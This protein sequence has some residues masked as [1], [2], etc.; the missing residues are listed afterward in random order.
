MSSLPLPGY[1][2]NAARWSF[3]T[4]ED[5]GRMAPA[6]PVFAGNAHGANSCVLPFQDFQDKVAAKSGHRHHD[7]IIRS[8]GHACKILRFVHHLGPEVCEEC[9]RSS[10]S[11]ARAGSE[12][13][14]GRN[15][16]TRRQSHAGFGGKLIDHGAPAGEADMTCRAR[17]VAF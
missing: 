1:R 17:H 6:A 7:A 8:L 13:G 16:S 3:T 12:F 4:R 14:A 11:S 10:T 5:S 15:V 2:G 9:W